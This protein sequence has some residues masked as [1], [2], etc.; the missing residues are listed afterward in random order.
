MTFDLHYGATPSVAP[1][2]ECEWA[3]PPA[4]RLLQ[5]EADQIDFVVEPSWDD[6]TVVCLSDN[7]ALFF[8][9][10]FWSL[11]VAWGL[12]PVAVRLEQDT[13]TLWLSAQL[14]PDGHLRLGLMRTTGGEPIEQAQPQACVC[15]RERRNDLVRR[16]GAMWNS[17]L[18]S[19]ARE[20]MAKEEPPQTWR[21]RP[22]LSVA[23][24]P[25]LEPPPWPLPARVAWFYLLLAQHVRLG[26]PEGV[27]ARDPVRWTLSLLS[28]SSFTLEATRAAWGLLH[29]GDPPGAE[30][31]ERI[32]TFCEAVRTGAPGYGPADK[33]KLLQAYM[34][35]NRARH[36]VQFDMIEAIRPRLPVAPGSHMADAQGRRATVVEVRGHHWLLA[37]ED[38]RLTHETWLAGVSSSNWR[39][40]VAHGPRF[41]R[42][43]LD[44]IDQRR[45]RFLALG[46][47]PVGIVCPVCGYPST[48]DDWVEVQDCVV[49]GFRLDEAVDTLAAEDL[50]ETDEGQW[51]TPR[52]NEARE[53]FRRTTW[54]GPEDEDLDP[55]SDRAQMRDP[56]Y[57]ALVR[58]SMAEWDAWLER[59]D[60]K[61][62]PLEMW[63][64][65]NRL[66]GYPD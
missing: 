27:L 52:I 2:V 23:D 1:A 40:P 17:I 62:L 32:Q 28:Q 36:A 57:R 34:E 21:R 64:R 9:L 66:I 29:D 61:R 19:R 65:W 10:W 33:A 20:D 16:L 55:E 53:R 50:T 18:P 42:A 63:R 59:P 5:P 35:V 14:E 13:Q 51:L 22:G 25:V 54:S 45:L 30:V 44:P 4:L 6:R 38:G 41:D 43:S 15:W 7:G 48:D 11:A 12:L 24:V 8:G 37:R 49:C 47:S 60:P 46:A 3:A 26:E 56:R 31:E 39:W 58:D